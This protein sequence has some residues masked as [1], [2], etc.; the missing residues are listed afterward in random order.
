MKDGTQR[1]PT[2]HIEDA[3]AAMDLMLKKDTKVI[4]KQIFNV[5]G[6]NNNF[7]IKNIVKELQ[8]Y[9]NNSLKIRWYGS[10]DHRSYYV[11]F[12]KIKKIGFTSKYTP[13]DGI[14]Q[15]VKKLENGIIDL[16]P[17]TITLDWYELLE[18]WQKRINE[19]EINEKLIRL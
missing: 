14:K 8:K 15:I 18:K 4:N 2:L 5:G 10:K 12:E 19:L 6:D 7:M 3:I 16:K 9:F 17:E 11:S 1:R 13:Y